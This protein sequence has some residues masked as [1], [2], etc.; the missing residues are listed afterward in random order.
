LTGAKIAI[1]EALEE[2]CRTRSE[3]EEKA[4]SGKSYIHECLKTF[5]S[6]GLV[7]RSKGTGKDGATEWSWVGPGWSAEKS[8][9][10][11]QLD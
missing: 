5:Y 3:I 10:I 4:D 11:V 9:V 1:I 2:G 7:S 6:S 8:N